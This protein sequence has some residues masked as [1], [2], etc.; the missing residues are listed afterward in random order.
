[1]GLVRGHTGRS[2]CSKSICSH[3]SNSTDDN[4]L[5]EIIQLDGLFAIGLAIKRNE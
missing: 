2:L 1:M 3:L 5:E 4:D